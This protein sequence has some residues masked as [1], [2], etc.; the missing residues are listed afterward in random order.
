MSSA[1]WTM[2][3]WF[4]PSTDSTCSRSSN[5]KTGIPTDRKRLRK[6]QRIAST[7]SGG[8]RRENGSPSTRIPGA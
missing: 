4:V 6:R 5:S 3:R 8:S 2:V 1:S 7:C